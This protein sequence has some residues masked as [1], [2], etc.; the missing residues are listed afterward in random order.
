M[1]S[2]IVIGG[3]PNGLV[4]AAKL[5][6]SGHRVVLVEAKD[7]LGGLSAGEEFAPGYRHVGIH[8]ETAGLADQVAAE[9]KLESFGMKRRPRRPI[10][11]PKP[12]GTSIEITG[13]ENPEWR[14]SIERYGRVLAPLMRS[15]PPDA[16][17]PT[18]ATL[19]EV[20]KT[21]LTLR[22]LGKK[23]MLEFLRLAPTCVT[24]WL[25]EWFEDDHLKAGLALPGVLGTWLGPWSAG[26]TLNLLL[27]EALASDEVVGGPTAAVQAMQA[28]AKSFGAHLR[29]GARVKRIVIERGVTRGVELEDGE[30]LE[31]EV[32][33]ATCDPKTA[34]LELVHPRDLTQ[35]D[36]HRM[37]NFRTRGTTG[38]VHLALSGPLEF[39]GK[40]VPRA[41]IVSDLDGLE[42]S[43]DGI[44]Y[45]EMPDVPALEVSV[46]T[47]DEP[48]L[49]PAGGEVVTVLASFIPYDLKG[50]WDDAAREQLGDLVVNTLAEYSPGLAGKIV[51]RDVLSP[52][53]LEERY[54]TTGGHLH[55]GEHA[56]DQLVLRPSPEMARYDTPIEGLFLG[57]GG[58]HPGGGLTGLPGYLAATSL[59]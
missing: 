17:N 9:L 28:A 41:R 22:R 49:A 6:D 51:H 46:P 29:T 48:S 16:Q 4:A 44:K 47:V 55:H 40:R 57:G 54:G 50:G 25:N 8:A 52:V 23:E 11:L 56:L 59:D 37:E 15:A 10:L 38:V 5:A 35:R 45:G 53:D 31:A 58:S 26:S 14:Q 33:V 1:S 2:V 32:V 36:A 19:V 12:D 27:H 42:R 30:R 24:D 20:G 18:L 3:G 34:L 13:D 7:Q 43:F 21:A 39:A